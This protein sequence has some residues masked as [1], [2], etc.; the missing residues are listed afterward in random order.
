MEVEGRDRVLGKLLDSVRAIRRSLTLAVAQS[1]ALRQTTLEISC[2]KLGVPSTLVRFPSLQP[3]TLRGG[4]LAFDVSPDGARVAVGGQ[5]GS[6]RVKA[7][8]SSKET[9]CKGHVGDVTVVKFVSSCLN[10][11]AALRLGGAD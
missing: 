8:A 6:L 4:V 5:G 1:F 9:V 2:D 3:A 10:A 7:T 11:E